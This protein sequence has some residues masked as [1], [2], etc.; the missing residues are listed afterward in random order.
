MGPVML[1]VAGYELDAEDREVLAHPLVGG[2]ILFTRNFHDAQQLAELVRQ[3]RAASRERLVVAVDQ[4]G[5]RVQR[6]REGFTRLPA[7]QAFAA[8][9]AEADACRLAQEAGWLM[10]AEM[11]AMD[12]D[13]SFAPVLDIGHK[14]AAIGDRSFHAQ[15]ESALVVAKSFITGMHSAGMKTTGKHFP[16]HGAVSA[17]SHKETP[18]DPRP[19]DEIRA[20][21]ML[22]FKAL[23]QQRLLD[24][25]MP[26]HVIYTDA[27]PRPASG[28]PFWL[29]QILRQELGFNGVIF[30]DD[31][32]MEGAAVM[33]SYPERAKASLDAGCDMVLACNNRDGAISVLDNLSPVKAERLSSLYHQGSFSRRQLLDSSRWK[34]A[35]QALTA[36]SDRWQAYKDEGK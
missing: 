4:E 33:G 31:L 8:L 12:I 2:V 34:Q 24:A 30:S 7:A 19:L 10:A 15:P 14:S 18:I 11:I 3:I 32:S 26:A 36:L 1:D 28:S 20:H 35:N 29:K 17:D 6:F 25:I 16:G 9:N 5:G 13:I 22:I 23:I 27:D 21:D